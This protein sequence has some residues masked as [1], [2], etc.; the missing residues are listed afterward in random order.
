MQTYET[1]FIVNPQAEDAAIDSQVSAVVNLIKEN[2]GE[3]HREDRIGS[4]RLAYAINNLTQGYYASIIFDGPTTVLPVLERHYKLEEAYIR[5]LTIKFEGSLEAPEQTD[6]GPMDTRRG[7]H[8]DTGPS[9][10]RT[11]PT[12]A[13]QTAK[14]EMTKAAPPAAKVEEKPAE[15]PSAPE[16][17]AK[18]EEK[19]AEP[20]AVE[21]PAATPEPAAKIEEKPAE[22]PK[23]ATPP[24]AETEMDD[25]L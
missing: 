12:P 3:I 13:P 4:R 10:S 22:Q 18:V 11:A 21:P 9:R 2:G 24:P 5:H 6:S 20:K 15:K 14:P 19:P 7:L 23:A 17:A 16:P 25:E 1:T 8:G